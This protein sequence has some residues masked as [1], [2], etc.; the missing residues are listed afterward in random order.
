M[1]RVEHARDLQGLGI[2][3]FRSSGNCS[4]KDES[5]KCT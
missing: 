5:D 1:L 3:R 4:R 2:L